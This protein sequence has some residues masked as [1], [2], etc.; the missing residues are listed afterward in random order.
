MSLTLLP[1]R[2]FPKPKIFIHC[3][4]RYELVKNKGE[5]ILK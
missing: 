3:I 5:E 2:T 4:Y 1:H